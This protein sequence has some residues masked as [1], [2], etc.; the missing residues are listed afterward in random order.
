MIRADLLKDLCCPETHQPLVMASSGL[1]Q[2]LN[3]Q[4]ESGQL[5]TKA[6][7]PVRETLE[8][9]LLTQ[10]GKLLYP[11]RHGLPILLIDEAIICL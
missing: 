1:V 3:T 11:V 8:S 5:R 6:G 2:Q 7:K 9:G 10:D 4:I